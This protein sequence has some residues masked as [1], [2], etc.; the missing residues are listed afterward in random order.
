M[1]TIIKRVGVNVKY[2][3]VKVK[4]LSE[5]TQSMKGNPELL[6][7]IKISP[8][9][10]PVDRMEA[11]KGAFPMAEARTN[12]HNLSYKVVVI[13]DELFACPSILNFILHHEDG[14]LAQ[15]AF[16]GVTG[17]TVET[18][19][20]LADQWAIARCSR[21]EIMAAAYYLTIANG[22]LRK[23]LQLSH[24]REAISVNIKRIQV[25]EDLI[26]S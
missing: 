22:L 5:I 11:P 8:A 18:A 26:Y 9:G 24:I 20:L 25:L 17:H 19:E 21:E 1:F 7:F 13:T 10:Y 15:M 4:V 2:F 3:G 6:P 12:I 14:H 16:P 23:Q